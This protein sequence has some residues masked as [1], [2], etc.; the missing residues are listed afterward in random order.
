MQISS[1]YKNFALV[2]KYNTSL[3]NPRIHYTIFTAYLF[4]IR[5]KTKVCPFE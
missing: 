3:I 5:M 1:M 2:R 4:I